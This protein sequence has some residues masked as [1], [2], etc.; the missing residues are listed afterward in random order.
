MK[1]YIAIF[2]LLVLI[3]SVS[4]LPFPVFR[5]VNNEVVT[6][7]YGNI[8]PCDNVTYDL[9]SPTHQWHNIYVENVIT[10]SAGV[11]GTYYFYTNGEPGYVSSI[12][13]AD[14]IIIS[15]EVEE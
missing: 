3:V 15:V 11:N 5:I 12:I 8:V 10:S 9:G 2:C 6:E 13:V 7:C 1:Y 14:G 4:C